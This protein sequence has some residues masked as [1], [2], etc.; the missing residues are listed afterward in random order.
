M[1]KDFLSILDFS[2]KE[3]EATIELARALKRIPPDQSPKV[4]T[5]KSV[6]L[7][8]KKPSLRT[9]V[10]F[11]VGVSQ[12]GGHPLYIT[13]ASIGLGSREAVKDAARVLARYVDAIVIRTFEQDEVEQI[14]LWA[15]VPVINAL[16]DLYHPC[17]IM[18]DML[19]IYERKERMENLS[20][21][22]LGDWNNITNSWLNLA[23]RLALDLRIGVAPGI[24]I[25]E[26]VLKQADS[27]GTSRIL[28]TDNPEEA[29]AGADV[30]YTDVW[31]SMGEKEKLAE[32]EELLAPFQVNSR[33]MEL[34]KPDAIF[35]HCLPAERGR[36]VTDNVID[37]PQS[38]VID[39]AENRLHIQ[40]AIIIKLFG[41]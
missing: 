26:N 4:L 27:I 38:V 32:R 1:N 41:M 11:E 34:A 14:A 3:I 25:D 15:N 33:I 36:E 2:K 19:T 40:K 28:V 18:G 13:D 29:V 31:A 24:E 9:R 21:A 16:T 6:T 5:G 30:I 10:S 35:M 8:F 12:L 7:I 39:E 37:S 23:S 17:Q 22:Y 20:I